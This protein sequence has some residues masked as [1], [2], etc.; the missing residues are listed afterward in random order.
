MDHS[1]LPSPRLNFG[2]KVFASR[3]YRL[4]TLAVHDNLLVVVLS[5]AKGLHG[6]GDVLLARRN[7]AALVAGGTRWD[8]VN[9]PGG[10][11]RYEAVALSFDDAVLQDMSRFELPQ[12]NA[13]TAARIVPTDEQF[14]EAVQ[15]TLPPLKAKPMS[16]QILQH[17]TME[18]LLMLAEAGH[19]FV[20]KNEVGWCERIRR[21]VSN[22]PAADWTAKSLADTFHLSESSLRRRL[23]DDRITLGALV[24]EVRLETALGLLQ[25]TSLSVGEVAQRCGWESHSRFSAVFQE[26]WGVPPSVVRARLK[27]TEQ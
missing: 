17:R 3:C 11:G 21:L 9:D 16:R 7:E 12:A 18:V 15:R 13:I 14:R 8:I 19:R 27:E 20:P 23:D 6:P 26:R 1:P 5:G 10:S 4:K 2:A 25:T 22:H 24:R